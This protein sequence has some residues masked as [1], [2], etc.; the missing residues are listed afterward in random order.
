MQTHAVTHM[1]R[2]RPRNEDRYL[3]QQRP[4]GVLVLGVADGLGGHAAGEVAAEQMV[5]A[6]SRISFI[7]HDIENSLRNMV[8]KADRDICEM[9]TERPDLEGMGTTLTGVVV[10]DHTAYW[11]QV[12]DSRLYLIRG[13][14]TRQI[15]K[16]QSMLQYLLD[17]GEITEQ[18]ARTHRLRHLLDQCVG[19]GNCLPETGCVSVSN[20]DL[21]MLSSDGLHATFDRQA[22]ADVLRLD[23][24]IERKAGMLL[25]A[26]LENDGSDNITA[27]LA[28]LS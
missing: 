10:R 13:G 27:V 23:C 5:T 18:E 21:L 22:L 20:G 12:G 8:R 28:R 17:E 7:D 11:V 19:Q 4:D 26:A 24:G 3:V 16:D 9:A 1:G 14:I 15:T 2:V 25:E 6:L